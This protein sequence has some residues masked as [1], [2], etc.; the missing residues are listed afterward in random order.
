MRITQ[1][2]ALVM[3]GA[4]ALALLACESPITQS[5]AGGEISPPASQVIVEPSE[6]EEEPSASAP[7]PVAAG[8]TGTWDGTWQIDP[9]YADVIGEFTME[10]V[11]SGDSFSG[12]VEIT[13]TDCGNGTV[14]GTVQGSSVTFGWATTLQPIQFAGSLNGTSMSG[15]WS[16][17]ACS[18]PSISLTGTWEATKQP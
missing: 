18:D 17:L 5:D 6:S 7:P 15:T 9:P 13:N 11:Q 12:P 10:L 16:A 3:V 4:L 1:R 14:D 8:V 2:R